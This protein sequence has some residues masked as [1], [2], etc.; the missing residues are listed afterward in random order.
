VSDGLQSDLVQRQ[1]QSDVRKCRKV[2]R[3]R[4]GYCAFPPKLFKCS[5]ERLLFFRCWLV[6]VENCH[7]DD[8]Q[9]P[10]RMLCISIDVSEEVEDELPTEDGLAADAGVAEGVIV[11]QSTKSFTKE[12]W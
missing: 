5:R 9:Q 6:Q 3:L 10:G 4:N 1:I 8:G 7:Y 12:L 2:E 11:K